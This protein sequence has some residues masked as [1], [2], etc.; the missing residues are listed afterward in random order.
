[1]LNNGKDKKPMDGIAQVKLEESGIRA[2]LARPRRSGHTSSRALCT[3]AVA[4]EE[5]QILSKIGLLPKYI[6]IV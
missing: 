4:G 6:L 5:R 2:N 3:R 1:M